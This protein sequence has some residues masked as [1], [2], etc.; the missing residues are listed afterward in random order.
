MLVCYSSCG[1]KILEI[2]ES[3]FQ[4]EIITQMI[5]SERTTSSTADIWSTQDWFV[6]ERIPV[7]MIES[8]DYSH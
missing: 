3:L 2:V 4:T 8:T 1:Y 7:E 6:S 5:N